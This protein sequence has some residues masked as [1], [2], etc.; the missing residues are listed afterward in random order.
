[1][2][3]QGSVD[4]EVNL[5]SYGSAEGMR[6]RFELVRALPKDI[7]ANTKAANRPSSSPVLAVGGEKGAVAENLKLLFM[8]VQSAV[9]A[10]SG[11]FVPEEAPDAL[12][13]LVLA[14]FRGSRGGRRK[15][16]TLTITLNRGTYAL[17]LANPACRRRA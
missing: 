3:G 9:V 14:F 17:Q 7:E 5:R 10:N 12:A 11:H 15:L 8:N 2:T 4:I 16:S 1:M 6:P 13:T